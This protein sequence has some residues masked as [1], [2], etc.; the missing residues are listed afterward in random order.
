M[1]KEIKTDV[2]SK[3]MRR[4]K[5][6][7]AD[8]R[9]SFSSRKWDEVNQLEFAA[10]NFLEE[11]KND[12]L[13]VNPDN[14]KVLAGYI[15]T[16][17]RL[18]AEELFAKIQPYADFDLKQYAEMSDLS[19]R[20]KLRYALTGNVEKYLSAPQM[21]KRIQELK[22]LD[23][24]E[25]WNPGIMLKK[26]KLCKEAENYMHLVLNGKVLVKPED[27]QQFVNYVKF[28]CHPIYN[29]SPAQQV[30]VKIQKQ[31]A[32]QPVAQ[33]KSKEKSSWAKSLRNYI[34][35]KVKVA[36]LTTLAVAGS[37][38][39]LKT[40]DAKQDTAPQNPKTEIMAAPVKPAVKDTVFAQKHIPS[41]V[42]SAQDSAEQKI[43]NNYYDNTVEIFL[44]A[45][46]KNKLYSKIESQVANGIFELPDGVSKEKFAY[47]V[48]IYKEYGL[49]TSLENALN[50]TTKLSKDAAQQLEKDISAAGKKGEGAKKIAERINHGKL[51]KYSKFDRSSS[52]LQKQHAKT[53]ADIMKLKANQ[54]R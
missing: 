15:N 16:F 18:Q 9:K 14:V 12:K 7:S 40:C 43:W 26:E 2:L 46:Q 21:K 53:L 22:K 23:K 1:N 19:M 29:D 42:D 25:N 35:S 38:L 10:D 54:G 24:T 5:K 3:Q 33:P 17:G 27:C 32:E 6:I 47:C 28:F 44:S 11:L 30:L 39:G 45:A 49:K 13:N 41:K 4:Y 51:K 48:A 34:S 50:S 37:L 8:L 31:I 52:R 20:Q 36:T